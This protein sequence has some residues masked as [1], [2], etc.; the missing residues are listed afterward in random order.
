MTEERKI[1]KG[2]GKNLKITEFHGARPPRPQSKATQERNADR[3]RYGF[4]QYEAEPKP[5][6]VSARCVRC[7]IEAK[8]NKLMDPNHSL[9]DPINSRWRNYYE[10]KM[11]EYDAVDQR[12]HEEWVAAMAAA[13]RESNRERRARWVEKNPEKAK[14]YAK[15]YRQTHLEAARES[16]RK[17][18]E[19]NKAKIA[20][21]RKLAYEQ[22]KRLELL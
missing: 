21:K 20:E 5:R 10:E 17:Y 11:K 1:C 4:K 19:A 22:K 6:R 8:F 12:K 15:Q 9:N 13:Q 7:V 14:E 18:Y 16:A 3:A 2:C